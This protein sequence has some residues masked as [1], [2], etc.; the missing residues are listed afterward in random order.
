MTPVNQTKLFHSGGIGNGDCYAA[1]LA[2]L[3][4]L[5]LWMVPPFD[6]MFGRS[7]WR[8]RTNRWL[9]RFFKMELVRTEGHDWKALPEF[10][11]ANGPGARGVYHSV[12]FRSGELAHDPHPSKSGVL[13]IDW[14]WHLSPAL[15]VAG[16]HGAAS[17]LAAL[18]DSTV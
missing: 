4:D 5:P 8:V 9:E 7:D 16:E 17:T 12:I 11:I 18:S 10:Y 13:A 14:C 6:Q 3:L 1:C 15:T 2:S